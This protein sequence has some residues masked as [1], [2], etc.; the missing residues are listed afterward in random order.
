MRVSKPFLSVVAAV[1]S[2]SGSAFAQPDD[3]TG[4]VADVERVVASEE[5]SGWFSDTEAFDSTVATLLQSVCRAR[6]NARSQALAILEARARALG[7]PRELYV[8]AGHRLTGPVER[9]LTAARRQRAL[10]RAILRAATDCPFWAEPDPEF[11]G[12][13]TDRKRFTLSLETGGIV[14]LRR[15]E[16]SWTFGGGGYGRLLPG[17]GFGDVSVLAGAEF[18]GGAMLKPNTEPTE[19]VINYFPALPV[20]VRFRNVS[21]HYDIEMAPV[22]LFQADDGDLSYGVRA[23]GAIGVM[24]LR[25]R[26]VLPWAG[27]AVAYEHYFPSGGRERAHFL[28]G[29]LR[30][31][32]MW[33]P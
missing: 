29:G 1:V 13:Q 25:T 23:G 28:R 18:G 24:A 16:G 2:L 15:T 27:I 17:Y 10:E 6:P 12:L 21:W 14:Q 22:A 26:G 8:R 7:D 31:G 32:L 33:D 11:S 19:L 9:A 5:G 4:L 30:I 3:V 20:V